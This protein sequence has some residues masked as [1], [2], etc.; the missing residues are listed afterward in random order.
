MPNVNLLKGKYTHGRAEKEKIAN[1]F[2]PCESHSK[3]VKGRGLEGFTLCWLLLILR[4]IT[5]GNGGH[6]HLQRLAGHD[7]PRATAG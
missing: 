7:V 5:V 4:R 6:K 1:V 2:L 3:D